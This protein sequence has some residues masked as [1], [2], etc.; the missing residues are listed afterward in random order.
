MCIETTVSTEEQ[1]FQALDRYYGST[2]QLDDLSDI[3]DEIVSSEFGDTDEDVEVEKVKE[4]DLAAVSEEQL[5][6]L[7]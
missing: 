5:E 7:L 4:L 1:I 6:N 2:A 3:V